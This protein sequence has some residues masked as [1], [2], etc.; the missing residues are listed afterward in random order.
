[1]T[2]RPV[3]LRFVKRS[4]DPVPFHSVM[5]AKG[6][7]P[8]I[9]LVDVE[10]ADGTQYFWTN[11]KGTYPARIVDGDRP[12]L[13]WVKSVG[14]IHCTRDARTDTCDLIVQN[15]SGNTLQAEGDA[16]LQSKEFEG[17][18]CV[19]RFWDMLERIVRDEFHFYLTDQQPDEEQVTFRL[20]QLTDANQY[21]IGCQIYSE[22]CTWTYKGEACRSTSDLPACAHTLDDCQ[23]R[24]AR[25][26]FNGSPIPPPWTEYTPAPQ[27][28]AASAATT[29]SP[30]VV[31]SGSSTSSQP[32]NTVATRVNDFEIGRA[33]LGTTVP[34][35]WGYVRG[36]GN[37]LMLKTLPDHSR[38][39][40]IALGSGEW[41]GF[42]P[43]DPTDPESAIYPG[44]FWLNNAPV[45][46]TSFGTGAIKLVGSPASPRYF[47]QGYVVHGYAFEFVEASGVWD[48]YR[49]W[50][51]DPVR[52]ADLSQW[53]STQGG[54][55]GTWSSFPALPSGYAPTDPRLLTD[56]VPL[57]ATG[58]LH[59]HPGVATPFA[60]TL[61]AASTGGD[62]LVDALWSLFPASLPRLTF[63]QYAYIAMQVPFDAGAPSAELTWMGD[64]RARKCRIFDGVG[65][66]GYKWTTNPAWVFID[67]G[68]RSIFRPEAPPGAELTAAEMARFDLPSFYDFSQYSD[69]ILLNGRKRWEVSLVIA[70]RTQL[71]QAWAQVNLM[72]RSYWREVRGKIQ[73]R[74]DNPRSS[75]FAVTSSH[76]A[77]G[78]FQA[79]KTNLRGAGNYWV[80]NFR[81]LNLARIADISSVERSA[82]TGE[83][84][85]TTNNDHGLL[86]SDQVELVADESAQ[87]DAALL[88]SPWVT[89]AWLPVITVPS[90][91]SFT[92]AQS[93]PT[94][95]G[96]GGYV[97]SVEGRF[98]QRAPTFSHQQHQISIG[99]VGVRMPRRPKRNTV[100]L[101][102]GNCTQQQVTRLLKFYSASQLGVDQVPY[103]APFTGKMSV[104]LDSINSDGVRLRDSKPGDMI[105]LDHSVREGYS[106]KYQVME[107]DLNP[108]G[109]AGGSSASSSSAEGSILLTLA[110]APPDSAY[111]DDPDPDQSMGGGGGIPQISVRL[112][113]GTLSSV[114]VG[115]SATVYWAN[116]A[117]RLGDGRVL[118]Y[119]DGAAAG[120]LAGTT[121]YGYIDDPGYLGGSIGVNFT[122]N[123]GDLRGVAGRIFVGAIL[124]RGAV[125]RPTW[126]QDLMWQPPFTDGDKAF[127]GSLDTCSVGII[128]PDYNGLNVGS[129]MV[130]GG[131]PHAETTDLKLRIFTDAWNR[132]MA[133]SLDQGATFRPIETNDNFV[134]EWYEVVLPN[135][136]DLSNLQVTATVAP[137]YS[138]ISIGIYDIRAVN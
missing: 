32:P 28:S 64:F 88:D 109:S 107:T 92:L 104:S 124:T 26:S 45:N 81:D 46:L 71:A 136:F 18:T 82:L 98:T 54:E 111:T 128:G 78:S 62:Q 50:T 38:G 122:V 40:I 16:A 6:T 36:R 41:E 2:T 106:A 93:G 17:A 73:L 23:A 84:T 70:Q 102:F 76:L 48:I 134:R 138:D 8:E 68:V 74:G 13:P 79:S 133:Y 22:Q 34:D 126:Y 135:P 59:F 4:A 113:S 29:V 80:G 63:S 39:A 21:E 103:H 69:E 91:N 97:G 35:C 43:P 19:V 131:F 66:I 75:F 118:N 72:S 127:D 10:T 95:S 94:G 42:H 7:T 130:W 121:L 86:V 5:A 49:P 30:A 112:I 77:A 25:A 83:M 44:A 56:P 108:F 15:L 9:T 87:W 24:G 100:T 14:P 47:P 90:A 85:V 99:T 96:I 55:Y 37:N 1:M 105:T 116:V 129:S 137:T 110:A 3:S 120:Q 132:C 58:F 52:R 27:T 53:H 65:Q 115:D 117:V 114:L 51:A 119:A 11:W 57:G 125:F 20:A 101:D 60:A 123:A 61:D 33:Q 89:F 31:V 67:M 12:Y